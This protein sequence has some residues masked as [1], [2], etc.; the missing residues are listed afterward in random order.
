MFLRHKSCSM[1][2][3]TKYS[4]GIPKST[5]PERMKQNLD[6]FSFSL[7]KD[8]MNLLKKQDKGSGVAWVSGDPSNFEK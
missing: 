4:G 3:S 1:G 5:N 6:V 7:S 2:S 8:E